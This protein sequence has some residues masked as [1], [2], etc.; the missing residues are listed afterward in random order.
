[1]NLDHLTSEHW[2]RAI[3]GTAP[4]CLMILAANGS[5]QEMNPAG[6][7]LLGA[8]SPGQAVGISLYDF[9]AP[10]YHAAVHLHLDEILGG[11]T[12]IL[13]YELIG[14]KK[15]R[16]WVEMHSALL[17]EGR[18]A[19]PA[20]LSICRNITKHKKME[21]QLRHA[22]K[23]EAIGTLSGGIAH[24]F[25]NILTAIIGYS[26]ILKLKLKPDDPVRSFVDQILASSERATGLTQ[27]LL[28]FSRKTATSMRSTMLNETVARAEKLIRQFIGDII[29]LKIE[30]VKADT[31]VV[32]DSGQIGQL[33]ANLATNARDAM[34]NGGLFSLSTEIKEINNEFI[35]NYGYGKLGFYVVMNVTDTGT[36][37]DEK[38]RDRIF[39]PFFTTKEIGKG[40]GLGCS[41][42]YGIVK[43]H[44]GF[45]SCS[46][47]PG[48]GTAFSIYL[49]LVNPS[50]LEPESKTSVIPRG[51]TETI[52]IAE[53]DQEVRKLAV[54]FLHDFGYTIVE[55]E[56]GEEAVQQFLQYKNKICLLLFD[57]VM[58]KINGKE[59]YEEIRRL[60]PGIKILFMSGYSTSTMIN[61]S[62]IGEGLDF[63][64]KPTSPETLLKKVREVLDK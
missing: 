1:M 21:A 33:L 13:E 32:A 55:S 9:V 47:E 58:P 62:I 43:Q 28:T 41:I 50:A 57:V 10:D 27:S 46:S 53:D 59:A 31:T 48:Q 14:F 3:I 44:H 42:V 7:A 39:E 38:T 61:K 19:H 4:E 52:L 30:L 5:I 26:N 11:C 35:R 24:D 54:T 16:L 40:T 64:L 36:G 25:N 37:M 6:L 8:N 60:S 12:D 29:E 17:K 18:T 63:V 2:L 51:G 23:M 45:I 15:N 22:Q 49:P 56:N 34:P 20:I